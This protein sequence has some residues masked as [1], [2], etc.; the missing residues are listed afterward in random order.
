MELA[1]ERSS[2]LHV[3]PPVYY[4]VKQSPTRKN[5]GF[6]VLPSSPPPTLKEST[7]CSTDS[8]KTTFAECDATE[9][10]GLHEPGPKHYDEAL[11][12]IADCSLRT[13]FAARV[14]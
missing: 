14:V 12:S 8:V 11:I 1:D 5:T 9:P 7:R 4:I 10:A 3:A 6:T 13:R 2:S